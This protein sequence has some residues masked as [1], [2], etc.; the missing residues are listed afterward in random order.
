M[1]R[2][3]GKQASRL[4]PVVGIKTILLKIKIKKRKLFFL[5]SLVRYLI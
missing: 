2:T 4:R 1:E 3:D 5:V